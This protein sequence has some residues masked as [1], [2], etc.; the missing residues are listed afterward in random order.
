[1]F[2]H[3]SSACEQSN[4]VDKDS[5]VQYSTNKVEAV[6]LTTSLVPNDNSLLTPEEILLKNLGVC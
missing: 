1:M 3:D 2:P 6:C 4:H 5:I